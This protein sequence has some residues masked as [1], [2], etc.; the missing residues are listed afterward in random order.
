MVALGTS[1]LATAPGPYGGR[2]HGRCANGVLWA[3]YQEIGFLRFKYSTDNGASFAFPAVGDS[4]NKHGMFSFFIDED[5]YAHVIVCTTADELHY[6]RGTP[7][8]GRTQWTWSAGNYIGAVSGAGTGGVDIVAHRQGTGWKA[9]IVHEKWNGVTN[10]IPCYYRFNITAA[11][12]ITADTAPSLEFEPNGSTNLAVQPTIDFHHTG[13]GKSVQGGTPHLYIGWARSGANG[14][15]FLRVPYS[16]GPTWTFTTA[17]IRVIDAARGLSGGSQWFN[18]MFDGTRVVLAGMLG[19]GANNDLVAH[20]RDAADTATTARVLV[21]NLATNVQLAFGQASYDSAGNLFFAGQNTDE[22]NPNRDVVWRKWVRA[23]NTLEAEQIIDAAAVQN[24]NARLLRGHASNRIEV[25]WVSAEAAGPVYTVDHTSIALNLAPTADVIVSPTNSATVD[26]AA[27]FQTDSGPLQDPN[28]GDTRAARAFR[29]KVVGAG[30]YDYWNPTTGLW[31][32]TIVWFATASQ[33]TVFGAGKWTNGNAYNWSTASQDAGGLQGPFAADLTLIASTPATVTATGP[34]GTVV[35]S[36]PTF[37]HSLVD[38]EGDP[39][40]SFEWIVESGAFGTSPGAG[41]QVVASGEIVSVPGR[42]WTTPTALNNTVTYRAFVRAKTNGQ[43]SATW[44]YVTFTLTLGV[45]AQ[46][47]H[48]VVLE[49]ALGRRRIDVQGRDNLLTAQQ[50]SLEDAAGGTTGWLAGNANTAIA[51]STTLSL[52]GAASLRLTAAALGDVFATTLAGAAGRPVIPLDPYTLLASVRPAT[53]GRQTRVYIAW[54]TAAEAFISSSVGVFAAS[55]VG[56]WT[57][58]LVTA[59]AP[60]TA[61]FGQAAVFVQGAAAA[62]VHYVDAISLAPGTSAVWTRGGL[63]GVTQHRVQRTQTP[64]VQS[65]WRDV[66]VV[67][68]PATTQRAS[69]YDRFSVGDWYHRV[70]PEAVV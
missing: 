38:P 67:T 21:D 11:H 17:N 65:S 25:S 15:R 56:A 53:V 58:Y 31:Q 40:Q 23:T 55:A 57:Q 69:V 27:G 60:A 20:E 29:R 9:H 28:A 41:V 3:V 6:Y 47:T 61:A 1:G 4:I 5:D 64:L 2:S 54:Y 66:G 48:S 46:P 70:V 19:D 33:L 45:P 37:T 39:Q 7:N 49:P 51:R 42:E 52:D 26:A 10:N 43:W 34:T 63:A 36:F 35:T 8:A 32:S 13:N 50:A 44:S 24:G 62:E 30:A 12:V 22:A 16:A 68:P 14:A 18:C 59:A